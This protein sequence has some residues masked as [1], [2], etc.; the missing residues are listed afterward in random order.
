V[1]V[2]EA[3]GDAAAAVV[4]NPA[5]V[6]VATAFAPIP[7]VDIKSRMWLVSVA[8]TVFVPSVGQE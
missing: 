1:V 4:I 2:G 3:V 8:L 5:L 6:Q 7:S